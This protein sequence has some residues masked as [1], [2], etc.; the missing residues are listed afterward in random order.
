MDYTKTYKLC[1]CTYI[2]VSLG[3]YETLTQNSQSSELAKNETAA[4]NN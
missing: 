3:S 1:K 4:V 2:E